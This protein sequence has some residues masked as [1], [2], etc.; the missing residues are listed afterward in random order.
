MPLLVHHGVLPRIGASVLVADGAMVIGD[1][2]L[3]DAASVW[4][5]AVLRGDINRIEI[6]ARTNVQDGTIAHVTHELPVIVGADV[7]I[8]H[9]AMIHGCTIHDRCLI[10]MNAVVLDGA[11]IGPDAVVAAGS[12]VRE[13]AVV[14]P[15]VL[16][17]GVPARIVRDLTADERAAIVRS[18]EHYVAYAATFSRPEVHPELRREA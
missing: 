18:A 1:V 11:V 15:G 8:G 4:F 12:V 3:D 10:G 5:N 6:G 16:V 9:M 14:P 7:T 2:R 17:A 13:R